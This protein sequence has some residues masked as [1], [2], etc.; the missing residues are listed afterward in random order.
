M[1]PLTQPEID[2]ALARLTT[3]EPMPDD[4]RDYRLL[5]LDK[6]DAL[7]EGL[8]EQ[9]KAVQDLSKDVSALKVQAGL[10]GALAGLAAPILAGIA[11]LL[12]GGKP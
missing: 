10:W 11:A 5:I 7:R 4:F 2:G 3:E 1:P 6:L 12:L 8:D 9:V